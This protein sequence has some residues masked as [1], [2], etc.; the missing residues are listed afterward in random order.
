MNKKGEFLK[1][2]KKSLKRMHKM[3]KNKKP[4]HRHLPGIEKNLCILFIEDQVP[5]IL[6]IYFSVSEEFQR[7]IIDELDRKKK[8]QRK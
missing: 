4:L 2:S 7:M 6:T 3:I 8:S 5:G 1:E